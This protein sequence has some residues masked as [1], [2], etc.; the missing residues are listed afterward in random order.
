MVNELSVFELLRFDCT[1]FHR[2]RNKIVPF[3][4]RCT[5]FKKGGGRGAGRD[6]GGVVGG[7]GGGGGGK[8]FSPE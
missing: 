5:P 2:L 4:I 8:T 3:R 6:G 7:G 1:I